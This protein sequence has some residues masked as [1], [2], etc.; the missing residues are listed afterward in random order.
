MKSYFFRAQYS[1]DSEKN[2][3]W[4]V[5]LLFTQK[6]KA[7]F[8]LSFAIA[9]STGGVASAVGGGF[10]TSGEFA[11]QPQTQQNQFRDIPEP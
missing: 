8:L 11:Y 7:Q 1:Y 4:L 2:V 5:F 9:S 3:S 10:F 6:E